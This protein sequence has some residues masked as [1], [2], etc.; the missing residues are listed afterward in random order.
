MYTITETISFT[1]S[2]RVTKYNPKRG[3]LTIYKVLCIFS[4]E[5]TKRIHNWKVMCIHQ[6]I[7]ISHI[8][9]SAADFTEILCW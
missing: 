6:S 8:R 5:C 7:C 2:F 1:H 9:N 3:N 4:T